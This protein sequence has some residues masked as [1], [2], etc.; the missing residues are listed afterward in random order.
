VGKADFIR[1]AGDRFDVFQ[2]QRD[3]TPRG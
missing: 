2:Q 1:L 3:H